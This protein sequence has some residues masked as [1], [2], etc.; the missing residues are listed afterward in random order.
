MSETEN[1]ILIKTVLSDLTGKNYPDLTVD[2]NLS[3]IAGWDS[4][5][6]IEFIIL[7]ETKLN[8]K[9]TSWEMIEIKTLGDIC[10]ILKSKM[11]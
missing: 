1:L 7:L 8:I 3:D 11:P 2:L 5:V 6:Q 9:F 10:N 4:I